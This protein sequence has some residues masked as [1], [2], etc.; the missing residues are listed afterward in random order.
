M[1]KLDWMTTFQMPE[2]DK[3]N[4]YD[5]DALSRHYIYLPYRDIIPKSSEKVMKYIQFSPALQTHSNSLISFCYS[6]VINKPIIYFYQ[7]LS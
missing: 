2:L 3:M 1:I 7:S 6:S 4:L 5:P